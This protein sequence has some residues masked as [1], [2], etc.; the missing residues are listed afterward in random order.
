MD[1]IASVLNNH[2]KLVHSVLRSVSRLD[3]DLVVLRAIVASAIYNLT[4]FITASNELDDL[5]VAMENLV[6]GQLSPILVPPHILERALNDLHS[7]LFRN[8]LTLT[9]SILHG[10][11]A[12]DFYRLHNFVAARQNT[13][14]LI[15][16]NF[17]SSFMPSRYK[18]YELQSFP[19]PVP[20]SSNTAHVTEIVDLPYGVAFPST[21]KHDEYIIFPTKP[22]LIDYFFFFGHHQSHLMRRFSVHHT[23]V[24]ALLQNDRQLITR[25]C[26]FHLR[27]ERLS[28]NVLPL[29]PTTILLTNISSLT[30]TCNR[31][32][33]VVSS[34]LQCQLTVP[35]HCSIDT[36]L[37]FIPPRLTDCVSVGDNVT[38]YH[39]VNLA[40]LQSFFH[41]EHLG[42]LL[43]D[44]LLQRP[45]RIDLPEFRIFQVNDTSRLAK[46]SSYSYYLDQAINIT[47]AEG[48]VFHS[49][50]ETLWHE[51]EHLDT[52]Y[53]D[54]NPYSLQIDGSSL[55]YFSGLILAVLAIVGVIYLCYRVKVLAALLTSM[56]VTVHQVAAPHPTL[57][58]FLSF[59]TPPVSANVSST[60]PTSPHNELCQ[61]SFPFPYTVMLCAVLLLL[62]LFKRFRRCT[63]NPNACTL[64]L[65]FGNGSNT[66]LVDCQT[67]PGSIAQYTFY[68]SKFIDHVEI[69]GRI[70]LMLQVS[71]TTLHIHNN[72]L[73]MSFDFHDKISLCLLQ[74]FRLRRILRDK[75]WCILT[76]RYEHCLYRI[77]LAYSD[78]HTPVPS[79]DV[80]VDIPVP[81]E[82]ILSGSRDSIHT[83]V[84]KNT[85]TSSP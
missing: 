72:H 55:I 73:N 42:S 41:D 8:G 45:L 75:F 67:L 83:V 30:S 29:T 34:C 56:H 59:F 23:C 65:E 13:T 25:F 53:F 2:E 79:N 4:S 49:L 33:A 10:D 36:F 69:V 24:S 77:D 35:C 63:S 19:V 5:K 52:G 60:V 26:Q 39:T 17:L 54:R 37:G 50:A 81:T 57:P 71:W 16:V 61:A 28:A 31:Q 22:E 84:H 78:E 80:H 62:L 82:V 51:A 12:A 74:S 32:P 21:V 27:P 43:G 9:T 7:D 48:Q 64:I 38:I 11:I 14:L 15:A 47:K 46:D 18:M 3:T 20:G 85:P 6:H 66:V 44:T 1:N 76:T 70:Q 68:A 58:T 40:V